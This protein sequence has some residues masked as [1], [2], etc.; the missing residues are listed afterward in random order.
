MA[1]KD[2]TAITTITEL[3][4]PRVK[5]LHGKVAVVTGASRGIGAAIAREL[6]A[7]GSHLVLNYVKSQD[8]AEQLAQELE[9][10][11]AAG[12][13]V[14]IRAD[15]SQEDQAASLMDAVW[16]HFGKLDIL[17][18]NAGI[19]RDRTFR[20]MSAAE[21]NEVINTNLNGVFYST[22]AA[23]PYLIEAGGGTVVNIGSVI[24]M[25]GAIGQANYSAAKAGVIGLTKTLAQEL[26]RF[27]ITVNCI[28]PGY[29]ETDMLSKV[30]DEIREQIIG[31]I[32]LR[33][34][35]RPEEVAQLVRFVSTEAGYLTGQTISL[36]GGL[37]I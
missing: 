29:I 1:V 20:K 5:T 7:Y 37:Y 36:N 18:N 19:T 11:G 12:A 34:F 25:S 10:S 28:A 4:A 32:P 3:Q 16:E 13:V 24:G 21:W 2:I 9:D 15:I 8:L 31:R 17:V 22:H 6:G 14:T 35:G 23:L 30:P 27:N 33:R 26:A